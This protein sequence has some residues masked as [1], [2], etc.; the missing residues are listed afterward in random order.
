MYTLFIMKKQKDNKTTYKYIPELISSTDLQRKAGK[1]INMVKESG[2]AQYIVRNNKPEA[3][4]LP[5]KEYEKIY[6]AE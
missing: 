4:I 3:V 5:I 1:I 2:Q 6:K